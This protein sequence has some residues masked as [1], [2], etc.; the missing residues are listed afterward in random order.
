MGN[1]L[2]LGLPYGST[3][4]LMAYKTRKNAAVAAVADAA[5]ADMAERMHSL[6]DIG[7]QIEGVM[8]KVCRIPP[9]HRYARRKYRQTI[10]VPAIP[11]HSQTH[12]HW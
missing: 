3:C 4:F 7:R 8:Q 10:D 5:T 12:A 11:A 6:R 1:H 9:P 2:H